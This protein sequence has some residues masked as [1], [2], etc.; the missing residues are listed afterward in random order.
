MA[1]VVRDSREGGTA[2]FRHSVVNDDEFIGTGFTGD[3][4]S[5]S[6]SSA[7]GFF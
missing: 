1:E 7:V 5:T 2:C 3:A 4:R 6:H